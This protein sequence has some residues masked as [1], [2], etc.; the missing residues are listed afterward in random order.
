MSKSVQR[1]A[2]DEFLE[3]ARE[4]LGD[5]LKKV[6]L[7]GSV[8]RGEETEKSDVDLLAVVESKQEK[9]ELE[10][11]A[12]ETGLEHDVSFSPIVK[13]KEEYEKVKDTVY[14]REVRSTGEIYV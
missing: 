11:I 9:R 14:G 13:T 8:S 7:Y 1:E 10:D 4:E 5:S 3:E 12:F 6:F 2:F